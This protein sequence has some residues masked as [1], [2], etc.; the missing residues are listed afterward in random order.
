MFERGEQSMATTNK[1]KLLRPDEAADFIGRKASTLAVWRCTGRYDLPYIKS[2][3]SV[4]YDERDLLA[5]L[6]RR[7]SARTAEQSA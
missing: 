4:L 5:F 6:D 2:G 1:P 7:K 3:S